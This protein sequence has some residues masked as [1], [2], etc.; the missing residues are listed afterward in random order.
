VVG[1]ADVVWQPEKV[2]NPPKAGASRGFVGEMMI[3][4]VRVP[5]SE[6]D[7]TRI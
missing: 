3:K 1:Q 6:N 2:K 4:F 7:I 5:C